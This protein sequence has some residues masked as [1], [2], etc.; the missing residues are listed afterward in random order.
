MDRVIQAVERIRIIPG[1]EVDCG[2]GQGRDAL[3]AHIHRQYSEVMGVP[4][5]PDDWYV[6]ES[7]QCFAEMQA[8][9]APN[10]LP[11]DY[12]L[13][14]EYYGGL[15]IGMS[16]Y[17]LIVDGIGPMVEEWYGFP[18]GDD[19]I[20][21]NGLL[22]IAT[23]VLQKDRSSQRFRFFLD[24]GG[25][26]RQDS[27]IGIDDRGLERADYASILQDPHTHPDRWTKLTD[28]FTEW[29]EQA[30]TTKGAFGYI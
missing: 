27:V 19:G 14:L 9:V 10:R 13:F 25:I 29:L 3:L 5:M 8:E 2:L 12:A 21:E 6:T 28:S 11:D 7:R 20:Y 18:F 17:D 26:I 4:L 23:L 24:L 1:A 22:A 15:S 16:D 30:A